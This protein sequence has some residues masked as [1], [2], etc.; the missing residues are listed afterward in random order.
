[1]AVKPMYAVG[2]DAG[3]RAT[4][5]IICLLEEGRMRFLGSGA[6]ESQG[7]VKGRI[8]DQHAVAAGEVR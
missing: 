1:M 7:W 2:L 4:R 6:V 8:A 3:S 5:I